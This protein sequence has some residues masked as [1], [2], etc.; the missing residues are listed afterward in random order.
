MVVAPGDGGA[1]A[2]RTWIPCLD[3]YRSVRSRAKAN[4]LT[5]TKP[6]E[7]RQRKSEETDVCEVPSVDCV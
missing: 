7:E 2:Q 3:T 6:I 4:R 5:E 1:G